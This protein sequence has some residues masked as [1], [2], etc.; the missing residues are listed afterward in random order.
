LTEPESGSK[1][2]QSWHF[3]PVD[4]SVMEYGHLTPHQ[5]TAS[6]AVR[7]VATRFAI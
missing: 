1:Y 3:Q 7:A 4:A 5:S 2:L 6:I